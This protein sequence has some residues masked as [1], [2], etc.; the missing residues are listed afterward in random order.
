MDFCGLGGIMLHLVIMGI[1]GSGKGTQA[2]LIC[3]RYQLQH[4]TTGELFR[5]HIKE[6]TELGKIAQ[7][8]I[9]AG[10]LVP[11]ELVFKVLESE[12]GQS[13]KGYILDGFPRT[14]PQAQ[15][16]YENYDL[17]KVIYLHLEDAV[18][19]ERMASRRVCSQCQA[20]YN[21]LLFPP[22]VDG[23]CDK[24]GGE[25]I[26]RADDEPEAIKQRIISF[27]NETEVL[28]GFFQEK[29]LLVEIDASQKIDVIQK[30]IAE[31]I[32]RLGK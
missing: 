11:D 7:G 25:V 13:E 28:K 12:M 2:D 6:Q 14:M 8:Y 5:K 30:K 4:I 32:D 19:I 24:C 18:A 15:Y 21:T 1:Q 10:N 3:D 23:V 16:L 22:K 17:S 20:G 27:H 31:E 26:T 9:S 29:G